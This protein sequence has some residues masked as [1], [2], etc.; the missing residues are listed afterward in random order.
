[1]EAA[2]LFKDLNKAEFTLMWETVS[3]DEMAT[4][5]KAHKRTL[6]AWARMMG[7]PRKQVIDSGSNGAALVFPTNPGE[8]YSDFIKLK[9]DRVMIIGDCEIPDHDVE[10]FEHVVSAA[11]HFKIDTLI[12]N[13]DFVSNDAF[14]K[15]ARVHAY[16][17]MFRD[18]VDLTALT[19]RVFLQT[20]KHI[21][22]L[23]GN[24]ERWL[25]KAV[26]GEIT[27]KDIL[28]EI[29]GL[30]ISDYPYLYLTSAGQEIFVCHQREYRRIPLSAPITICQSRHIHC[31][32]GHTHRQCFGWDP[33][34]K[35]WLIE[36][37]HCRSEPHTLYKRMEVTGHPKWNSGFGMIIDGFPYLIDRNNLDF[38]LKTQIP[39]VET[40]S[41]IMIGA[42]KGSGS[43]KTKSKANKKRVASKK[44]KSTARPK[45]DRTKAA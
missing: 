38:W 18:Q 27:M 17:L 11:R 26:D 15:W 14:S 7:L 20:F 23:P 45:K 10:M 28:G 40:T 2:L 24:H 16:R 39:R 19:L 9:A 5:L 37:G 32:C 44:T 31:W 13:G 21:I 4:R 25:P 42:A 30:E 3:L 6:Q 12:I 41:K 43:T 1:M 36:G 35:Y 22:Y 33:S 8:E 34:G 29:P